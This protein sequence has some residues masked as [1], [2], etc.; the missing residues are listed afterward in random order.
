M[1]ITKT[2]TT[3]VICIV[4]LRFGHATRPASAHESCAKAKNVLPGAESHATP[5][6][7]SRPPITIS[8]R[9]TSAMSG[10]A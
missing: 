1:M 5:P 9:S 8:T 10:N 4:S 3:P 7:A 6:A 2:N